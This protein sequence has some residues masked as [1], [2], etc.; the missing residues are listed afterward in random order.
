MLLMSLK[1]INRRAWLLMASHNIYS[2]FCK[3]GGM[4]MTIQGPP[5][6]TGQKT[7]HPGLNGNVEIGV[8]SQE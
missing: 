3:V 5:N 1:N 7:P 2:T 4:A 8:T 6:A